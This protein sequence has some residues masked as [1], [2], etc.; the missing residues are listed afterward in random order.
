[1]AALSAVA[2][3][4]GAAHAAIAT[5]AALVP[6]ALPTLAAAP[7]SLANAV[8]TLT[9]EPAGGAAAAAAK[10]YYRA[11]RLYVLAIGVG[12]FTAPE[13]PPLN[14][15]AKDAQDFAS[16]M[17]AQQGR[18]YRSVEVKLLTE[19][20]ATRA[21]IV[22]AMKWLEREVT[23]HDVGMLFVA[24]HGMNH[25]TLG[26]AFV[27]H[28]YS[29]RNARDTTVTHKQF[30]ATT[31]NLAGKALF[32]IDTC[33]AGNVL[34]KGK[35]TFSNPDVS[36]VINDLASEETGVVVFSASTG[37]Q[38]ALENPAWGNG[39]FTK[40]L[41]EGLTGRADERNSGRITHRMLDYY[42][43]DRV[44]ALTNG[45]QSAVTVAP[46]GVPDFPLALVGP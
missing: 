39:A 15:P 32:F 10:P 42:I 43:T 40:S 44:K 41:V 26:Y 16:A 45:V 46:A 23:Q 8:A 4:V 3:A 25:P 38:E 24:G 12:K 35:K 27:P 21:A 37:R 11:P 28:D 22:S 19:E 6:V 29:D 17:Q 13:M 7:A 5:T 36:A 9:A 30:K 14:L 1:M 18:L 34:G 33:H 31:E 2:P 20:Q